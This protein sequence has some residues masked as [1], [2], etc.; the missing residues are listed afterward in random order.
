MEQ[1]SLSRMLS[2]SSRIIETVTTAE[3]LRRLSQAVE[4]ESPILVQGEVG[5]GKSFLIRELAASKGLE[6]TLVELHLDDQTDIKTL[7]GAYV[8][9]DVPGEFLWQAGVITQAALNGRWLIIEDIDRAPLEV[10]AS[11]STL[12]ERRRLYLPD[13]GKEVVVH[14]SFRIFGTRSIASAVTGATTTSGNSGTINVP[15]L[16]HFSYFWHFVTIDVP[17]NAEIKYIVTA[18]FPSLLPVVVQKLF[19][20][21]GLFSKTRKS[22]LNRINRTSSADVSVDIH[23]LELEVDTD[24]G[25]A[26]ATIG[27]VSSMTT[28]LFTLRDLMKA[29]HRCSSHSSDF[30]RASG[31]LTEEMRR[32]L[33]CEVIDV[34][35]AAIRDRERERGV[36]NDLVFC[37]GRCWG[38]PDCDID[39]LILNAHPQMHRSEDGHRLENDDIQVRKAIGGN[40][41]EEDLNGIVTVGRV[42]LKSSPVTDVSTIIQQFAFNRHSLRMLERLASCVAMD[43]PVLLVGETG[44]GKTTSIQELANMTRRKLV[45]QNLSLSTDASDLFGGFRPVSLRQLFLPSYEQFL[46]LFQETF[47]SSQNSEFVL[48]VAQAFRKQQWKKM[49]K[50]FLKASS[51]A[52]QKLKQQ[53]SKVEC[54][55]REVKC[56]NVQRLEQNWSD[57]S[58]RSAR[59]ETNLSR[60]KVGFAFA[61]VDGLLVDAMRKGYWVLLDEINLAASETLQALAGVLDGQSLCLSER[62]DVEPVPRHTNFRIFAAMNPPTDVGKK[63]LPIA[64]RSR[65]TELYAEEVTDPQDLRH[66]VERVLADCGIPTSDE[67]QIDDIVSVYLGCR[68]TADMTLADGAGQRPKFSLRSLTRSLKAVKGFIDI[69]LRPLNRAIFEGFLLN[70]YTLLGGNCRNFMWTFLKKSLGVVGGK[71]ELAQPPPRP[72]GKRLEASDWVLVKP[73]WLRT[74]SKVPQDWAKKNE[75]GI[76]RFVL[77]PTVEA[78][79]RDLA[80]AVA[81]GVAPILLQGPTSVGKTSMIEY[82]AACTGHKCVR[83]NNHEHTDVQEYVG[84]YITNDRG[85]LE[86]RD[87]LLVDALRNGYWIILD[88]KYSN[89]CVR[90]IKHLATSVGKHLFFFYPLSHSSY[91]HHLLFS[92]SSFDF[93]HL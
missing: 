15:S 7:L 34:F 85:H 84:G 90:P 33:L 76:T 40:G 32:Y 43:E 36:Y 26:G 78:A 20:T 65:F 82:L 41:N 72:G 71:K 29:A 4:L 18:K 30:N 23:R 52:I 47:S 92:C 46:S 59:F 56:F 44:S 87:G 17:T 14:P 45:V 9:S 16:R 51:N 80:A 8:C 88:G 64:L 49:L 69:G 53:L 57:F 83:I 70:F 75:M 1:E 2:S 63:E 81:A 67:K 68:A 19:E 42:T 6:S 58:D 74:G 25:T 91:L 39:A 21:Y 35:A 93:F 3:N 5:C 24:D 48:V 31:Q 66:V 37:L 12:L 22:K 50:A 86:F 27:A 38:V 55:H 89:N 77:T 60:I 62:G 61:F 79:V 28:R 11:L 73:F 13:R 10:A 54:D